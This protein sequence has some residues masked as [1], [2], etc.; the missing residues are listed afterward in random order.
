MVAAI[1]QWGI[2]LVAMTLVMGWLARSRLRSPDATTTG[3]VLLK[4][5]V[6]MLFLGLVA[7]GM[8]GAFAVLSYGA[9]T[10]GP[11]VAAIFL[12]FVAL[13]AYVTYSYFA[14]RLELRPDGIVYPRLARRWRFAP[15]DEISAVRYGS[16]MKW[17][18]FTLRDGTRLRASAI[19]I[20]L[21]ALAEA[22]LRHVPTERIAPDAMGVLRETADGR[23]PSVWV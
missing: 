5:P 1:I 19:L 2:Y 10:G 7:M 12:V 11:G 20:G 18:V 13:G 22:T 17:F 15:W 9:R 14:D 4:Q 21:P 8:F 6:G 16:A 23:P 3:G